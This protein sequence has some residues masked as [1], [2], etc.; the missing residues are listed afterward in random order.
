MRAILKLM[1]ESDEANTIDD[2]IR[3]SN[4][5]RIYNRIVYLHDVFY[6]FQ[7]NHSEFQ[8]LLAAFYTPKVILPFFDREK[9]D[10][11]HLLINELARH[12]HNYVTSAQ[13]L[14]THTRIMIKA[15]YGNSEFIDEY[16]V[17]KDI[18]FKD[19]PLSVF[20][21][22]LRNYTLHYSLPATFSQ[23]QLSQDPQT[24]QQTTTSRALLEK[25]SLLQGYKWKPASRKYLSGTPDEIDLMDLINKHYNK[26]VSFYDWLNNRLNDNHATELKWLENKTSELRKILDPIY[27]QP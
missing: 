5:L 14:A 26:F 7:R 25:E 22:D 2:E 1:N 27:K 20:V 9:R 8:K 13:T 23:I 11:L 4:A 16:Q 21:Q 12:F 3:G 15:A 6:I 19:D 17:R 10:D 18:T 24:K